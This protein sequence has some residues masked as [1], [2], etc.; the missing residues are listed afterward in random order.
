LPA[1][2]D[3]L[4]HDITY[5]VR[6]FPIPALTPNSVRAAIAAECAFR[7]DRYWEYKG[8][9]Q[10]ELE[11]FQDE[12]LRLHAAV[13]GLDEEEF[14]RCV[15]AERMRSV[16]ERDILDAWSYGVTGTPT[17]FVNGRRFQGA[18]PL[19]ELLEYVRLASLEADSA[20]AIE[21]E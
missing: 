2:L 17:F 14:D 20:S 3:T 13:V 7:Q 4:G 1:L 16:V 19:D 11:G 21:P 15:G 6:H 18:R 9:L 8:A 5:V 12:R 10:E